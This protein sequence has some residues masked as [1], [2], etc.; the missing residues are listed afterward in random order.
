MR[1]HEVQGVAIPAMDISKLGVA[2]AD[3]ILQHGCKYWLKITGSP[4]D[5]LE[6]LRGSRLLLQRFAKLTSA[7]LFGLEQADILNGDHGLIGKCLDESDFLAVESPRFVMRGADGRIIG[8]E[9]IE[10]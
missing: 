4:A 2:D 9:M 3:G 7:L 6:H 1:C 5:N 8:A 10:S